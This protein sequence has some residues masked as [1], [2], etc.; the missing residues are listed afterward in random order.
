MITIKSYK[1]DGHFLEVPLSNPYEKEGEIAS[2]ISKSAGSTQSLLKSLG[3]CLKKK[4]SELTSFN[5]EDRFLEY[6]EEKKA[7]GLKPRSIESTKSRLKAFIK[8]IKEGYPD[9]IIDKKIIGEYLKYLRYE[10][11]HK[12]RTVN[13]A[14]QDIKTFFNWLLEA[15]TLS[16][17]SVHELEY[18]LK[19]LLIKRKAK[20]NTT[21]LT[22][23]NLKEY[24]KHLEVEDED[25]YT[26]HRA[27]FA[28]QIAL[29]SGIRSGE[30]VKLTW[31]DVD[32]DL[33]SITVP[34]NVAKI[35]IERIIPFS[36]QLKD[37]LKAFHRYQLD[38]FQGKLPKWLFCR[39]SCGLS[40]VTAGTLRG[41]IRTLNRSY[42]YQDNITLYIMRKSFAQEMQHV[43]IGTLQYLL[44][45]KT[46]ESTKHYLTPDLSLAGKA[47]R[48]SWI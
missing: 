11:K 5:L 3:G 14:I 34:A 26:I 36:P 47:M 40:Q 37:S 20:V 7:R 31:K 6:L 24:K 41:N 8:Y 42:P 29:F 48:E 16:E 1:L 39:E 33:E 19:K 43:G 35:G 9:S 2:F 23:P 18:S 30:L 32:F 17:E 44:G 28:M 22:G 21:G 15:H 27:K 38:F 13:G 4:H 10:K 12:E 46:L 25:S 45:Q